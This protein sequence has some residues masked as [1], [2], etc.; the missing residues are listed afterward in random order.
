MLFF[1]MGR[2][3]VELILVSIV[4]SDLNNAMM[5]TEGRLEA[6]ESANNAVSRR[7]TSVHHVT[8][9]SECNDDTAKDQTE[10]A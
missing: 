1:W 9:R 3:G 5:M 2:E 6:N 8:M 10:Y 7:R 4:R